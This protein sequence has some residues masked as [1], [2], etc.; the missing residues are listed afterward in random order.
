[1]ASKTKS[2]DDM[3]MPLLEA[4]RYEVIETSESNKTSVEDRMQVYNFAWKVFTELW[5][6]V[7]ASYITYYI[8]AMSMAY[9]N[10]PLC[11]IDHSSMNPHSASAASSSDEFNFALLGRPPNT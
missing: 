1:M 7:I 11:K 5:Y 9:I 8:I 4:G 3:K 2:E 10:T 6:M